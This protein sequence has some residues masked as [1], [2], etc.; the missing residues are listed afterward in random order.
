LLIGG[1]I[2]ATAVTHFFVGARI[3]E[4]FKNLILRATN[5]MTPVFIKNHVLNE[6]GAM[7]EK[8]LFVTRINTVFAVFGGGLII[9]V[10][11]AFIIRWMGE[12]YL[13][14]Y[15]VLVILMLAAIAEI[16]G[17]PLDSVLYAISRHSFL[18][19]VNLVEGILK[20]VLGLLLIRYYGFLGVAIATAVPVM[21][22]RIFVIPAY[23]CEQIGLQVRIYFL[24]LLR[25]NVFAVTYLVGVYWLAQP[26]LVSAS[27]ENIILVAAVAGAIYSIAIF[28]ISFS[29]TERYLLLSMVLR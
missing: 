19:K 3:V 27:Y 2:S 20:V 14:A 12:G 7:R 6:M 4:Y 18:A 28:F 5:M 8:V 23:A 15:P 26:W 1:I 29:R 13:D 17:N 24:N 21:M 11:Q 9:I 22:S 16:I 25:T 10:G